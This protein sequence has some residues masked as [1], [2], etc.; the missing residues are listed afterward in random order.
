VTPVL[1]KK[2]YQRFGYG[3]AMDHAPDSL[4]YVAQPAPDVWL[5]ALDSCKYDESATAE[6]PVVSGRLSEATLNWALEKL[7]QAQK[8]GKRVIAFMHHGVNQHFVGEAQLFPDYLVDDWASVSEQLAAAGLKVIFTGHY[9][10]SDASW[11]LNTAGVPQMT[12]CDVETASLASFP[13]AYRVASLERSGELRIGSRHVTE[14]DADTGGLPFQTYAENFQ[15]A[16]LPLLVTY[17]IE[18]L[19]Q[20]P[21][22]QAAAVAPWVVDALLANYAGDE[23]P[24]AA[25]EA[26][27]AGLIASPEPQHTLGLMLTGLWTDLPPNDSEVVIEIGDK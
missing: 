15:R 19:F 22:A 21:E 1:F 8:R 24:S 16:R 13:C 7:Q 20:L 25:T 17:Q 4:S 9:H 12:L 27:L 6:H 2:L 26:L 23:T 10:S 11:P 3:Q 5:L 18:Q 14:I